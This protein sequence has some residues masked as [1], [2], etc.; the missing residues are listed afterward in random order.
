M[1]TFVVPA[2]V[3][4]NAGILIAAGAY[5]AIRL[6]REGRPETARAPARTPGYRPGTAQERL[7]T[8]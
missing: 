5:V 6:R 3:W 8:S 4:L 7:R 1:Q 2:W